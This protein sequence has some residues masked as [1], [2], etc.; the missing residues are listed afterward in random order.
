MFMLTE[1]KLLLT[2][3]KTLGENRVYHNLLLQFEHVHLIKM[4]N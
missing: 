1:D 2:S 4:R 3:K